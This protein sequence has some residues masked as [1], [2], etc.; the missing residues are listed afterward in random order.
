MVIILPLLW[1][2]FVSM[3]SG[4]YIYDNWIFQFY[5][6]IFTFL[7]IMIYSLMDREH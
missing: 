6:V 2:G 1:Y 3:F 7:P 4:S 5:N